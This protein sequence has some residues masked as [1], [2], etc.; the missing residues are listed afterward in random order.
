MVWGNRTTREAS[1]AHPVL[2][3]AEDPGSCCTLAL[4][5]LCI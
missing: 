5:C 2:M 3:A 4:L 1:T